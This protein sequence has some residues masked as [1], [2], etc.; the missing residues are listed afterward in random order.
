MKHTLGLVAAVAG[1]GLGS[2]IGP[3]ATATASPGTTA[4][5]TTAHRSQAAG[6]HIM[7]NVDRVNVPKCVKFKTN[8]SG[9]KDHLY[10]TNKCKKAKHVKVILDH[11]V[12][13]DCRKISKGNTR[14]FTWLYPAKVNKVKGC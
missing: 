13:F 14:H 2:L 5:G 4:A 12:D 1:L 9:A 7:Q 10:I 11:A 3:A 6:P 8:F